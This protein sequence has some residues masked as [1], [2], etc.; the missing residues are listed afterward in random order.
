MK[1]KIFVHPLGKYE[2]L[3]EEVNRW[4]DLNSNIIIEKTESYIFTSPGS[5]EERIML[6]LW[7]RE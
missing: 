3:E 2:I 6:Q 4:I 7:Y 1:L 5:T